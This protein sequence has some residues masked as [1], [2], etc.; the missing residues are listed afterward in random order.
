MVKQLGSNG[1]EEIKDAGRTKESGP[2]SP[3]CTPKPEP[4]AKTNKRMRARIGLASVWGGWLLD[5]PKGRQPLGEEAVR[6][7]QLPYC[8]AWLGFSSRHPENLRGRWPRPSHPSWAQASP[9]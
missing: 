6:D 4:K 8:W 1:T 2:E 5:T 3:R 9:G 7:A